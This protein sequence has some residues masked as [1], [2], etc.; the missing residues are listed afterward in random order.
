MTAFRGK[1]IKERCKMTTKK[2]KLS[3]KKQKIATL[4]ETKKLDLK[5]TTKRSQNHT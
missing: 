2:H 4:G 3:R 1:T 5:K